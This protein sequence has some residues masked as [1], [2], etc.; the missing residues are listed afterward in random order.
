MILKHVDDNHMS[1]D[2][3][4]LMRKDI[5]KAVILRVTYFAADCGDK[6]ARENKLFP[7]PS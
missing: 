1:D 4:K 3:Q 6:T 2:S 7:K 5:I